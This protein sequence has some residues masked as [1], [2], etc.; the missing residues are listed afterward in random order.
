MS[1]I[2][3][4]S[5]RQRERLKRY[6]PIAE[7]YKRVNP[8]CAVCVDMGKPKPPRWTDDIHHKKGRLGDLLFDTRFFMAVCR[9]H[10]DMID[11]NRAWAYERGYLLKRLGQPPEIRSIPSEPKLDTY[12]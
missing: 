4:I 12:D 10:H 8:I 3:P 9:Q 5:D 1:R 6:R 7:A 2:N 11:Q